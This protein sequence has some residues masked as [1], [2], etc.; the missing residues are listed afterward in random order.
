[1]PSKG[2]GDWGVWVVRA[3]LL[4]MMGYMS[5]WAK[6]IDDRLLDV[7]RRLAFIEGRLS[8]NR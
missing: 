2:K 6:S 4:A 3:T 5:W 1:M 8:P 7:D